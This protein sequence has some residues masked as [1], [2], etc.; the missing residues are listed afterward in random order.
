VN[1]D[2]TTE[3]KLK[4]NARILQ[5]L[6][7]DSLIIVVHRASIVA[8]KPR[9][10]LEALN[11]LS[12]LEATGAFLFLNFK[13]TRTD[14][15]PCLHTLWREEHRHKA[16]LC[17]DWDTDKID[18]MCRYLS[19]QNALHFLS[20]HHDRFPPSPLPFHITNGPWTLQAACSHRTGDGRVKIYHRWQTRPET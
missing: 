7:V 10:C 4:A 11:T 15:L 9:P 16:S 2:K 5:G 18:I 14:H 12:R 13:D 3:L 19:M 6:C 1:R 8:Q 20:S 17:S